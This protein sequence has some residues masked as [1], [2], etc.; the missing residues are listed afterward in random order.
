ML[1]NIHCF[2]TGHEVRDGCQGSWIVQFGVCGK[3]LGFAQPSIF[4][5]DSTFCL[6]FKVLD[7]GRTDWFSGVGEV[8]V[9]VKDLP[10]SVFYASCY[11]CPSFF[12]LLLSFLPHSLSFC[13]CLFSHIS[14]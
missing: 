3:S 11:V 7:G 13:L 2:S 5:S 8:D 10:L 4:R 12:F 1:V 14:F 9:K 6:L